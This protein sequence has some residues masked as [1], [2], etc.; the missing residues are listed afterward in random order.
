MIK[1]C[2]KRVIVVKH[3]DNDAFEEAYFIVK[4]GRYQKKSDA[5]SLIGEADRIINRDKKIENFK[6]ENTFSVRI[7]NV[8]FFLAGSIFSFALFYILTIL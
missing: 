8:L 3:P 1:G 2:S 7:S 4:E 6:K 5:K